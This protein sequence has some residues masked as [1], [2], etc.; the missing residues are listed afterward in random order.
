M[1]YK[2]DSNPSAI[3]FF[4]SLRIVN[5]THK[6]NQTGVISINENWTSKMIENLLECYY[7]KDIELRIKYIAKRKGSASNKD[8]ESEIT[9]ATCCVD[10]SSQSNRFSSIHA[11][12]FSNIL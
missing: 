3:L 5:Y 9:N 1:K 7:R 4:N 8:L 12:G 11:F 2:L 6:K 10:S